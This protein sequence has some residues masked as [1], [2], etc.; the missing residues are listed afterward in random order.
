MV[1]CTPSKIRFE[2]RCRL[3]KPTHGCYLVDFNYS[4]ALTEETKYTN[5]VVWFR[6][7]TTCASMGS[8]WETDEKFTISTWLSARQRKLDLKLIAKIN[9]TNPWLF[10][11]RLQLFK[12]NPRRDKAY[13]NTF[14]AASCFPPNILHRG[15]NDDF[16][17]LWPSFWFFAHIDSSIHRMIRCAF[18]KMTGSSIGRFVDSAIHR[19]ISSR[20]H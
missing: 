2:F 17:N 5:C 3:T 15:Y 6:I 8:E 14:L 18:R 7:R 20:T 10:P 4:N 9:Q 19:L 1:K 12:H 13:E 16:N 11:D